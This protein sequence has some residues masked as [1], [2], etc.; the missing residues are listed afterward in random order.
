MA[1]FLLVG[2]NWLE[3]CGGGGLEFML[4]VM[5]IMCLLW[6]KRKMTLSKQK[7]RISRN[8]SRERDALRM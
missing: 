8:T 1:A 4:T 3:E 7:Q 2:G 6:K 5:I